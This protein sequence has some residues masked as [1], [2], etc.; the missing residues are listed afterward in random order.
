VL[1]IGAQKA[2]TSW[3]YKQLSQCPGFATGWTKEYHIW[4]VREVPVLMGGQRKLRKI[5]SLKYLEMYLMEKF[6]SRYFAHFRRLLSEESSLASDISPSYCALA[7]ETLLQIK[8]GITR[9]GIAFKCLFIMRDPVQRCLSAFNM[10]RNRGDGRESVSM[11]E[12]VD[13]AF[14]QYVQSDHA[15][16]RTEYE[17]TI[18]ALKKGLAPE[19]YRILIYEEMFDSAQM[20]ALQTYLELAFKIEATQERVHATKY[21]TNVSAQAQ[22]FCRDSFATTYDDVARDFPQVKSSGP[23][24][25]PIFAEIKNEKK[26]I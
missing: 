1:G 14:M 20:K 21:N 17:R 3:L 22:A 7:P 10:N 6:P 8:Q 24:N 15:K 26:L 9:H 5:T 18:A 2:G 11:S 4:D 16:I 12:D 19:D 13:V 25:F 23:V